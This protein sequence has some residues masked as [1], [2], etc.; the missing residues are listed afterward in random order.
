M[1]STGQE[2]ILEG[3]GLAELADIAAG[4][5]AG[6][7]GQRI[8]LFEGEMGVGK[9]TLIKELCSQLGV[10]DTVAS[11]TFA[12]INEYHTAT[13]PVYHFDFYRLQHIGEA[14]EIGVE[15]YFYSGYYCF[16]EW[17]QLVMPLIPPRHVLVKIT[18]QETDKWTYN[19]TH[20]GN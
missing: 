4:L 11:P 13:E 3:S 12:I 2:L 16:I 20:H 10:R 18:R 19:L 8:W 5:L 1:V 15:D 6:S 9:T 14:L 7:Q 17:P